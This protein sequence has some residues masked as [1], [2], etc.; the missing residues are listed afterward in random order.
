M[1]YYIV[2]KTIVETYQVLANDREDAK[3]KIIDPYK[4][5]IIKTTVKK[6]KLS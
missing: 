6:Q 1:E 5:D 3:W 2:K 4:I